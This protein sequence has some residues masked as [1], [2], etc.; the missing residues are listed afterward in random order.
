MA[1]DEEQQVFHIRPKAHGS[2]PWTGVKLRSEGLD[3]SVWAVIRCV[4]PQRAQAIVAGADY[5]VRAEFVH[6][7]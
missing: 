6:D 3:P 2:R 5:L 7:Q 1:D 4:D